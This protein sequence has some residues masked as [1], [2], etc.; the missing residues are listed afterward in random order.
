MNSDT[1]KPIRVDRPAAGR[2][3]LKSTALV[4]RSRCTASQLKMRI[5]NGK[6]WQGRFALWDEERGRM[7]PLK[8]AG[9]RVLPPN[10]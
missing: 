10:S 5:P 6:P 4:V 3:E 7:V 9:H 2:A 1:V 8:S